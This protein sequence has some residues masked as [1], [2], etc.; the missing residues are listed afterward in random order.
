MHISHTLVQPFYDNCIRKPD[1]KKRLKVFNDKIS[2]KFAKN[3]TLADSEDHSEVW[4]LD[5]TAEL[6]NPYLPYNP[7]ADITKAGYYTEEALDKYLTAQVL[8]PFRKLELLGTVNHRKHG[9]NGNP[10][11]FSDS[12]TILITRQYEVPFDEKTVK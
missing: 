1:V 2:A 3:E 7:E 6:N 10:V 11:G 4:H 12:N 8:L 9:A 5:D